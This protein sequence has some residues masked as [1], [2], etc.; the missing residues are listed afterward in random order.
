MSKLNWAFTQPQRLALTKG[1]GMGKHIKHSHWLRRRALTNER[2]WYGIR[3]HNNLGKHDQSIPAVLD[4]RRPGRW[5]RAKIEPW[6][7]SEPEN[8]RWHLNNGATTVSSKCNFKHSTII[9]ANLFTELGKVLRRV[10]TDTHRCIMD[11]TNLNICYPWCK[12]PSIKGTGHV[13]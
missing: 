1:A 11:K 8:Q 2:A 13:W 6:N 10:Y 7:S 9:C 4:R 3:V 5:S 12:F